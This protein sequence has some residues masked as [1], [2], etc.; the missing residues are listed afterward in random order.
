MLNFHLITLLFLLVFSN[1]VN[2]QKEKI[3]L[4]FTFK[5]QYC[6]GARPSPQMIEEAEKSKP[7][8]NKMMVI[9]SD[10]FKVDSAKTNNKGLLVIK[11][12]KGTYSVFESWKFYKTGPDGMDPGKF[13]SECLKLEWE[14]PLYQ[15]VKTAKKTSI[16]PGA[17][18]IQTCPWAIPCLN[19]ENAPPIPE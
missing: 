2:A 3:T 13:E 7:Y 15:I 1:F 19:P 9:I 10:K 18:I 14:R 16:Q 12:K 8:A 5:S 17:E 11:L 4:T 6:G